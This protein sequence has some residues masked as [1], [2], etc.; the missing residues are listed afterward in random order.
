MTQVEGVL[1][2]LRFRNSKLDCMCAAV[3][4]ALSSSVIY[5][6]EIPDP[7]DLGICEALH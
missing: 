5:I 6:Y 7:T 1:V 4:G 3:G 2:Y